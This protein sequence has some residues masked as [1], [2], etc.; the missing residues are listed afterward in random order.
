MAG[1]GLKFLFID[2]HLDGGIKTAWQTVE[3]KNKIGSN[4]LLPK[5]F[6]NNGF[7]SSVDFDL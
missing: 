5:Y 1:N 6:R 3:G 2:W 7:T 4:N